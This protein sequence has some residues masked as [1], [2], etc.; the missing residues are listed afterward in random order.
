MIMLGIT[1]IF[2]FIFAG[3]SMRANTR[4]RC[5]KRLPMQW[6]LAGTV[7]WSAPRILAL[8]LIPGLGIGLLMFVTLLNLNVMPR[9]GQEDM[10]LP[11]TILIG[12]TFIAVQLLHFWMIDKTWNS[13]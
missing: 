1:V 6:S 9:A 13:N 5:H 12:V 8:S 3:L 2:A 4:Y 11:V 7:N 10:V